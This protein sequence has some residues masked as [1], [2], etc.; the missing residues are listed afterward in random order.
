MSKLNFKIGLNKDL[1]IENCDCVY[2]ITIAVENK[3]NLYIP[4]GFDESIIEAIK[5]NLVDSL[6]GLENNCVSFKNDE[7]TFNKV[8]DFIS[9]YQFGDSVILT[10][11]QGN[12][13]SLTF[14][15][16]LSKEERKEICKFGLT[17]SESKDLFYCDKNMD[18][19]VLV[20]LRKYLNDSGYVVYIE[21]KK[22]LY[23][24]ATYMYNNVRN[25]RILRKQYVS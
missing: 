24:Q 12:I 20:Q 8:M 5:E 15:I 14:N 13:S 3:I 18:P 21:S 1:Y 7:K 23:S 9:T 16:D 17:Y 4:E 10:L 6:M 22:D 19:M 11:L 25:Q 2:K